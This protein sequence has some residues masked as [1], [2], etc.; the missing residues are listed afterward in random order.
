MFCTICAIISPDAAGQD[1]VILPGPVSTTLLLSGT[2]NLPAVLSY[3]DTQ[4]LTTTV[5]F[6][7]GAVT[8]TTTCLALHTRYTFPWWYVLSSTR[9]L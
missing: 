6:P 9:N 1:F 4:G 8:E 2:A 5:D 3:A 7:A